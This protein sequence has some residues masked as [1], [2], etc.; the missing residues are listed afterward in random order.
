MRRMSSFVLGFL[1]FTAAASSADAVLFGPLTY[2][3]D[4]GQPRTV[5]RQFRVSY[6]LGESTLR[7]TNNGVTSGVV[8]LNGHVILDPG[9]F[10]GRNASIL[11][12]KITLRNGTNQLD[13]E[14]RSK[15][16]TSLTIDVVGTVDDTPPAIKAAVSPAPNASG[17]NDS[18]VVVTFA[19]A[20]SGS[21][22]ASCPAPVAV[23]SEGAG[24][25][26]SGAARDNAG[27][28]AT[29]TIT[30]NVDK[31]PPVVQASAAPSANA[32]GWNNSPVVVTF[33]ATDGLSGVTPGSLSPPTTLSSDG[34]GQS[35]TG[36]AVDRAGNVG[37][38]TMSGVNVDRMPPTMSVALTPAANAAGWNTGPVTAH[39]TCGDAL[40]GVSAC[41]ADRII[42]TN[43]ATQTV[44]G[45]GTDRAGNTA[46]V[47]SAAFSIYLTQPIAQSIAAG[48]AALR[49]AQRLDGGWNAV[50][51]GPDCNACANTIGVDAM[52]LLG[53]GGAAG[54]AA[55][56]TAA[57]AAGDRLVAI[58][59]AQPT[60]LPKAQHIE[61]LQALGEATGN[62]V[63]ASTAAAW[64]QITIDQYPN[65]GDR[66]NA[67]LALRDSQGFRTLAAW[68][69]AALI[70]AAK[71]VG[72]VP[73]A[74]AAATALVGAE[75]RW[76]DTD[77]THRFDRCSNPAGCGWSD[78]LVSF[79][80]TMLAEGSLLWAIHDLT[81]FTAQ[82]AEYRAFLLAQQATAASP[83]DPLGSWDA[84]D[85]QVTAY[86]ILGLAASGSEGT[87]PALQAA[88]TF[89]VRNQLASGGWPAY[90]RPDGNG[91]DEPEIDSEVLQALVAVLSAV[92]SM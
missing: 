79:D 60:A 28:T 42:S 12:R 69:A 91:D 21:G 19:C 34:A 65:A 66:V 73:Y 92:Q 58:F 14:L 30:V 84:G 89:F 53:A 87:D 17:W 71:A 36:S 37:T 67:L 50:V 40:S 16:G 25:V 54:D 11:L 62:P 44:S 56:L 88:T 31:T 83:Q 75:S 63:Y 68:D 64:F 13:V 57:L 8:A 10:A 7:V 29:A 76:K 47:T 82:I 49:A 70:R 20:D 2:A 74:A 23:G 5:T 48:G 90:V 77:P 18:N 80:W 78:D 39:F 41:P 55:L 26:I 61:F 9:D 38:I 46:S 6:P 45:A 72:H 22:V 35:A 1:L 59:N 52:G 3:R 85:L 33:T 32:N 24:R 51:G 4:T 27:N 86:A 15:P 43:G 81:G